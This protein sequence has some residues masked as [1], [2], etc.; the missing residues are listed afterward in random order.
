VNLGNGRRLRQPQPPELVH[1]DDEGDA[2]QHPDDA[3]QPFEMLPVELDG[4]DEGD[5]AAE[6]RDECLLL[7]G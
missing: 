5:D 4:D 6:R 2:H 7:Q 1:L 3:L